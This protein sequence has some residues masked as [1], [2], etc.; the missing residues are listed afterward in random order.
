FLGELLRHFT[1]SAVL[2]IGADGRYSVD[3][4]R[5]DKLGV[6]EGVREVVGRRL[7][8][9]GETAN[10]ILRVAAVAGAEFDAPTVAEV[11]DSPVDEVVAVLEDA[12][13]RGLVEETN[14][15]DRWR[16]AH[17][18]VRHTLLDELSLSRR[19]RL[20]QRIG[21][22][23]AG[24]VNPDPS[25]VA[26]HLCA[27]AAV[28]ASQQ[29][30]DWAV[31]AARRAHDSMAW[32]QEAEWYRRALEAADE[33]P[34]DDA[35]RAE[36]LLCLGE[37]EVRL[38]R[39]VATLETFATAAELA[40]RAARPDLLGRA[41]VGYGGPLASWSTPNDVEGPALVE[42]ADAVLPAED[43]SLRVHLLLKRSS[44]LLW[45]DRQDERLRLT[46]S[47][48][49]MA[50]RLNDHDGMAAALL[51]YVVVSTG[52]P[53]GDELLSAADAAETEL[54]SP[55]AV[56]VTS[57][58]SALAACR[59]LGLIRLSRFDD[60]LF[61]ADLMSAEGD[62]HHDRLASNA[63]CGL[64]AGVLIERGYISEGLGFAEMAVTQFAGDGGG[65][66]TVHLLQQARSAQLSGDMERHLALRRLLAES[67]V[68][69]PGVAVLYPM[70]VAML[71][72]D[73]E[74]ADE[75]MTRWEEDFGPRRAII[76]N[77]ASYYAGLGAVW[78]GRTDLC[79]SLLQGLLPWRGLW[80]GG[81]PAHP[82]IVADHLIGL[83]EIATGLVDEARASLATARALYERAGARPSVAIVNRDL[84]DL[85]ASSGADLD[86]TRL[87]QEADAIDEALRT[88]SKRAR[89]WH[90]RASE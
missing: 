4:A 29:A 71:E 64:R 41:A 47:A 66:D 27:A 24:A 18:L 20:H 5:L 12:E 77:L 21:A 62:R 85:I 43:S 9:L 56:G 36:L 49:A 81:M 50:R 78:L 6:P 10:A 51:E 44:W 3:Q 13:R 73:V 33:A 67:W 53:L 52:L 82:L 25:D 31:R 7:S 68:P 46:E 58:R 14:R 88:D 15:V 26:H 61:Q 37:A 75:L 2:G 8:V 30:V 23:L 40:R 60:A 65:R 38:G 39:P 57:S 63:A 1:E 11:A 32:E 34:H 76:N 89:I 35:R 42:E 86:A 59:A 69:H 19:A 84:T 54:S 45:N 83:L 70:L 16:F 79:Q 17:A 90:R 72:D 22:V 74:T 28:G 87:L 80:L 55:A 48:A